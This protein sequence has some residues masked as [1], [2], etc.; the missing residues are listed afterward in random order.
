MH[1]KIRVHAQHN[2]HLLYCS[3]Q[4]AIFLIFFILTTNRPVVLFERQD[5]EIL[6]TA[7]LTGKKVVVPVRTVAVDE[8]GQITDVSEY[9]ECSSTDEDVLKVWLTRM[10]STRLELLLLLYYYYF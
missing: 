1:N 10:Y 7:I 9:A 6:N 8:D 2:K 3:I 4:C 5:T